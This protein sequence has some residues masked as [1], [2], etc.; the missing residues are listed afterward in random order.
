MS[1]IGPR[2]R[3]RALVVRRRGPERLPQEDGRPGPDRRGAR[4]LQARPGWPPASAPPRPGASRRRGVGPDKSSHVRRRR[5][6]RCRAADD[7]CRPTSRPTG[8]P[9]RVAWRP[10]VSAASRTQRRPQVTGSGSSPESRHR[11]LTTDAGRRRLPTVPR[12]RSRTKSSGHPPVGPR[13]GSEAHRD[14]VPSA[15]RRKPSCPS[16]QA[17]PMA[18]PTLPHPSGTEPA[19]GSSSRQ[20]RGDAPVE[21]AG[22]G[23]GIAPGPPLGLAKVKIGERIPLACV[24]VGRRDPAVIR[25]TTGGDR[26]LLP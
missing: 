2:S 13:K 21:R 15:S 11:S 19:A 26:S 18:R 23:R 22:R 20:R 14:R 6:R 24:Q 10:P 9:G 25:G 4:S 5:H 16:G 3:W 17:L 7:R 8:P 12:R 1:V